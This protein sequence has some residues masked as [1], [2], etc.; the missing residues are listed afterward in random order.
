M[1]GQPVGD[2]RV[3]REGNVLILQAARHRCQLQI[4][5]AGDDITT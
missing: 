5:N 2:C 3:D 4:H 1:I